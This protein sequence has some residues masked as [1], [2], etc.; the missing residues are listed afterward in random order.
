MIYH[1][2]RTDTVYTY[3]LKLYDPEVTWLLTWR[4]LFTLRSNLRWRW[5]YNRLHCTDIEVSKAGLNHIHFQTLG[6]NKNLSLWGLK[7]FILHFIVHLSSEDICGRFSAQLRFSFTTFSC[8]SFPFSCSLSLPPR[9]K[10]TLQDWKR[11]TVKYRA[12]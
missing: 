4:Q 3:F 7:R 11:T 2:Q 10:Q 12:S 5:V 9:A 1:K 8:P 6:G